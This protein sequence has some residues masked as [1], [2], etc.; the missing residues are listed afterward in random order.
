M[1]RL[2]SIA[3]GSDAYDLSVQSRPLRSN[4]LCFAPV[5]TRHS[6]PE[7]RSVWT[8]A[9]GSKSDLS[10]VARLS[11][12]ACPY[13]KVIE[14]NQNLLQQTVRQ[15][16]RTRAQNPGSGMQED[17]EVIKPL[18]ETFAAQRCV[19]PVNIHSHRP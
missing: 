13:R 18:A 11:A 8:D 15:P 6:L 2:S 17:G 14:E 1:A 3:V 9:K 4:A 10:A 12:N 19:T 7:M 16:D 5:I